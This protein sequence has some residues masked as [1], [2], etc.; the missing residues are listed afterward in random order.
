MSEHAEALQLQNQ[1]SRDNLNKLQTKL[2]NVE[3]VSDR[4]PNSAAGNGNL[5]LVTRSQIFRLSFQAL[6]LKSAASVGRGADGVFVCS[7]GEES[8]AQVRSWS[9]S[10]EHV[11]VSIELMSCTAAPKSS[12]LLKSQTLQTRRHRCLSISDSKIPSGPCLETPASRNSFHR[13]CPVEL[14]QFSG[15]SLASTMCPL[16]PLVFAENMSWL[17]QKRQDAPAATRTPS[18][19]RF[20][21]QRGVRSPGPSLVPERGPSR[22]LQD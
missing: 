5:S 15:S 14:D 18:P 20:S 8:T 3:N 7:A 12:E 17:F 22:G 11:L 10:H 6:S 9:T 2:Q 16:L 19:R 13:L 4:C 21:Q 1:E